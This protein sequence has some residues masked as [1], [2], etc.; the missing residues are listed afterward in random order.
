MKTIKINNYENYQF[1][2]GFL[3]KYYAIKRAGFLKD[4]Y[5]ITTYPF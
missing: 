2:I 5:Y 1:L 4:G 3:T